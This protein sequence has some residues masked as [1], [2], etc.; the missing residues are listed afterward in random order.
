MNKIS[1]LKCEMKNL[2]K[3]KK[4]IS[5]EIFLENQ[6]NV[7]TNLVKGKYYSFK[8]D[9]WSKKEYIIKYDP[10]K[11]YMENDTVSGGIAIYF[12]LSMFV[13]YE[14]G[15][16]D[17]YPDDEHRVYLYYSEISVEEIYI[18]EFKDKIRKS[19]DVF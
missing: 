4:Q 9:S 16:F 2:E 11:V 18:K 10:D 7:F 1:Q 6:K 15:R 8:I 13:S 3:R 14:D 19:I 17:F 5:E 12:N